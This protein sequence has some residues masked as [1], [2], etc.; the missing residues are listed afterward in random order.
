MPIKLIIVLLSISLLS[1]VACSRASR[2]D[3]AAAGC[4]ANR[5]Q[6]AVNQGYDLLNRGDWY[7]AHLV[8][9]E[10]MTMAD[11]CGQNET[12]ISALTQGLYIRA[13]VAYETRDAAQKAQ[14]VDAGLRLLSEV[15]GHRSESRVLADLYDQMEPKFEELRMR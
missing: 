13:Y 5:V 7:K 9:H 15:K 12:G 3:S 8:G 6:A 2:S 11:V 10:L 1:S 4:D 14:F